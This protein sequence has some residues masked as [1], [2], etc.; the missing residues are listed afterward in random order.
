MKKTISILTSLA[1]ITPFFIFSQAKA[2]SDVQITTTALEH[3]VPIP[4]EKS[5]RFVATVKNVGTTT[6]KVQYQNLGGQQQD[7]G[8]QNWTVLFPV[9]YFTLGPGEQSEVAVTFEAPLV[10]PGETITIKDEVIPIEFSWEGGSESITVTAKAVVLDYEDEKDSLAKISFKVYDKNTNKE[11]SNAYISAFLASGSESSI[12]QNNVLTVPSKELI[13]QINSQYKVDLAN[14]GYHLQVSAKGY[15][16]YFESDFLPAEGTSEKKVYLDTINQVGTYAKAGSFDTGYSIWWAKGSSDNKYFV[17]SQGTHGQPGMEK[18]TEGKIT[19]SDSKANV[20][21]SKTVGGECWGLDISP[22]GKYVSAG[23]ADGNIYLWNQSGEE[24]WKHSNVPGPEV[25]WVE[26]S[27]DSTKLFSGPVN[28]RAEDVGLFEVSSGDLLW[29]DDIGGY[30]REAKFS[31]DSRTVYAA[32]SNGALIAYNTSTGAKKWQ[33]GG[34]YYI[35]F[36]LGISDTTNSIIMAGKGRNFKALDLSAGDFKWQTSVDQTVTSGEIASDGSVIGSTVGGM[37]YALN[38]NGTIKWTRKY[39]GVGHNGVWYTR[40]GQYVLFGGPNPTL[41]DAN[42]N[43]LWQKEKDKTAQMSGPAE[44]DTGG[45]N[46]TWMSEDAS[47][48]V[49]GLDTGEV[50]I[51][52]G[53]VGTG[54]NDYSQLAGMDRQG[55]GFEGGDEE[56]NISGEIGDT[57]DK[58]EGGF[59]PIILIVGAGLV[60]IIIVVVVVAVKKKKKA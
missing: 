56:E 52:T 25:R 1:L 57:P 48:L 18:I 23:C 16:S 9:G 22:D 46:S 47:L 37:S 19:L 13:E 60:I 54:A 4:Y 58:E 3:T 14:Q 29:T 26:F 59:S 43:V 49:L 41:F 50:E 17:F 21:W 34:S 40:N 31:T 2:V 24:V 39:G 8:P 30:L 45:A 28:N 15:K 11:I 42:G 27:P 44:I 53:S 32:G 33:A 7:P 51:Y 5:Y 6:H 20:L 35:P 55:G 38:S 10:A 12:A 36:V